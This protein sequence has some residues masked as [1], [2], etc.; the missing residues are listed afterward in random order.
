MSL[1]V[2]TDEAL[3]QLQ[4]HIRDFRAGELSLDD[5]RRRRSAFGIY[6]LRG[7]NDRV[8]A[9]IK[10]PSGQLSA[11]QMT[12][13]GELTAEFACD[14]CHVTT[15]QALQL[16]GVSLDAAPSLLRRL[17][18]AGLTTMESSG[19]RVRNI[20]ACSRAGL[21]MDELFDVTPY[22][23]AVAD[24]FHGNPF[25]SALPRKFKIGFSGCRKDCAQTATHDVGVL[26]S[27]AGSRH[28]FRISAGGGLGR[29]PSEGQLLEP[30]T[31]ID[32]LLPTLDAI[33]RIFDR[34][35]DRT[36]RAKARLK[37]LIQRIGFEAFRALVMEQR[38]ASRLEIGDLALPA[39]IPS[40]TRWDARWPR[41][42][43]ADYDRWLTTNAKFQRQ[44]GYASVIVRVPTGDL[45]AAQCIGLATIARSFSRGKLVTTPTQN[46]LLPWVELHNVALVYE[47]LSNLGLASSDAEHIRDIVSCPGVGSCQ[48]GIA[49]TRNLVHV[50]DG[51]L[52]QPAYQAGEI[53]A[54]RIRASGCHNACARHH[55]AD[56]GF[57]GV[58]STS[59]GRPLPCYELLVGG[60]AEDGR[61]WFAT[62]LARLPARH[63]PDALKTL[64]HSFRDHRQ[65]GESF[66]TYLQR[67][68]TVT[69]QALLTPH[70]TVGPPAEDPEAYT[71]WNSPAG[72]FS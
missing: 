7:T 17:R 32:Q 35:G 63:V 8:V 12:M 25:C 27:A 15:R 60:G 49:A 44:P 46:V 14:R 51:M 13:V 54:L 31:S 10:V 58:L 28:G 72:E 71:D 40:E 36:S 1:P 37:Y 21:C 29:L 20:V 30:F 11:D 5:F 45:S 34:L 57:H 4:T 52:G 38:A 16:H 22:A 42:E 50:L 59:H 70:T 9:R 18:D 56:I 6:G 62:P 48:I 61:A 19:N 53:R 67:T 23:L 41:H 55:V 66:R 43:N 2:I 3:A 26:A 64:L 69:L 39:P 24:Y 47:E 33:V 68:G 65:D